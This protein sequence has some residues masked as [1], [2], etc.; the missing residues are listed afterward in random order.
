MIQY[1]LPDITWHLSFNLM[2]SRLKRTAPELFFED[3][4]IGSIYGCF[5]GCI[6]NGG[7]FFV[8]PRYTY[9]QIAAVFDQIADE[10]L[11]TRLTFTTC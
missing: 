2:L 1:S 11:I 7:R 8:G 4:G 9:D 6:M 3:V 10:G 5:P